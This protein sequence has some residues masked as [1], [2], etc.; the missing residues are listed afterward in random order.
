MTVC[1][2]ID[3]GPV[4][5]EFLTFLNSGSGTTKLFEDIDFGDGGDI[6]VAVHWLG[7]S[8][9]TLVSSMIGAA[10]AATLAS[11][12]G[13]I[14][15]SATANVAVIGGSVPG[16]LGDVSI[17]FSGSVENCEIGVYRSPNL[18]TL[19]P[20]SSP[21][22]LGWNA[23]SPNTRSTSADVRSGGLF[24]VASSV[25]HNGGTTVLSGV[26]NSYDFDYDSANVYHANGG[27]AVVDDAVAAKM[28]TVTKSG[29]AEN[30]TGAMVA[31]P[32]R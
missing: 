29:G 26:T 11:A 8:P 4:E 16:G 17:T 31:V 18:V 24:L 19:T 30:M 3:G 27:F 1:Q 13:S 9:R 14:D 21:G 15:G 12:A 6:L 5:A 22:Q 2:F 28:A 25:Y 7:L 32:F 23:S 20:S 10:S